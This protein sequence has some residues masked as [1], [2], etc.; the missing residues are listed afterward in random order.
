MP[1]D[2]AVMK[3]PRRK[4]RSEN[5]EPLTNEQSHRVTTWEQQQPNNSKT[6]G[7]RPPDGLVRIT[8][9]INEKTRNLAELH[10]EK[11]HQHPVSSFQ[12]LFGWRRSGPLVWCRPPHRNTG[13][14]FHCFPNGFFPWRALLG[15]CVTEPKTAGVSHF[16][17]GVEPAKPRQRRTR[18]VVD[19]RLRCRALWID[20]KGEGSVFRSRSR[21]VSPNAVMVTVIYDSHVLTLQLQ[22]AIASSQRT[23]TQRF[24]FKERFWYRQDIY[25]FT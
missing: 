16:D 18:S 22:S 3:R 10:A 19:G 7:N 23:G 20:T 14:G 25:S 1:K 12:V 13:F 4:R 2:N 24:A 21:F 9:S 15:A 17:E 5:D 11:V 6:I 8:L